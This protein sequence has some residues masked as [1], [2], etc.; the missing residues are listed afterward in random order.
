MG[1]PSTVHITIGKSPEGYSWKRRIWDVALASKSLRR[2]EPRVLKYVKELIQ[3][4]ERE[5]AKGGGVVDIGMYFS[6]FTFDA[7]G[8]L[9]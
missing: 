6:F 7:M 5:R 1:D 9:A 4:L 2:Y 8:D 3:S